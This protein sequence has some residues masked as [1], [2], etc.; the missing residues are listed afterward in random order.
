MFM[1]RLMNHLIFAL[2]VVL[3]LCVS[4]T[5]FWVFGYIWCGVV[6]MI[7]E[8]FAIRWL[9]RIC[10][11]PVRK[12]A[13]LLDAIDNDDTAIHFYEQNTSDDVSQVNR[14]LNQIAH[15]LYNTKQEVA[16]R[17]K[18]YELILDFVDTGIV[19][20]NTS[21][22]VY[23]KNKA[24]LRLLALPVFTHIRQ[25]E[26]VSTHLMQLLEKALPGDKLQVQLEN[27][28]EVVHLA[29]RV[30]GIN[31]KNEELRIVALNNIKHEL[32]E[33][34]MDAWIGL[35]RVLTHEIMNSLTPVTSISETLLTLSDAKSEEMKQGLE[36]ISVT[37][38]G[39]ITF[40]NSYRKL[41]RLP[42]P[43][44]ALF[45]VRPFL[46]RMIHLASHLSIHNNITIQLTQIDDDL[47]LFADEQLI[48]QVVT[49]LLSNAIQAIDTQPCGI[50]KLK[51]Y[52]DEQENVVI[53]VSNNGPVIAPE[54]AA[55]MFIPFFST[56]KDGCGIGLSI[57]K[58]IMR[59]NGGTLTLLPYT[60][61]KQFTTFVLT[62]K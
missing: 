53:E 21:G 31:I 48:G 24:A 41:T 14:M 13:F 23:Q 54:V 6:C 36:T 20:L 11:Q 19:V 46:E 62:L 1:I 37:G 61:K 58:Q 30:S 2:L 9:Y 27:G 60:K 49:N 12:V 39:L 32:D 33:Q 38:K 17:E 56:K 45:D 43:E 51:A 59:L 55:Q 10:K 8:L 44:P 4:I 25:L 57:S 7:M 42:Q 18:Y 5:L 26:Q 50:I 40:V 35:T 28:R 3:L 34:E 15:I 22:A 47:M 52:C 29:L 16:Q